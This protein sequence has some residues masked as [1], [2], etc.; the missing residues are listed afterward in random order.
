MILLA[1]CISALS[2]TQAE[3][4]K[5]FRMGGS[6]AIATGTIY[7][8]PEY[9]APEL[10]RVLVFTGVHNVDVNR[11]VIEEFGKIGVAAFNGV[12]FFPPI[13]EYTQEEIEAFCRERHINGIID[14][15]I[16]DRWISE[17]IIS[18]EIEL[19]LVNV[20]DN[21]NIAAVFGFVRS[22]HADPDKGMAK[23]FEAVVKELDPILKGER[24]PEN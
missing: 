3:A 20:G 9:V 14:T 23:F 2:A 11:S 13:K 17:E 6:S 16:N 18:M 24:E 10:S 8:D 12:A 21:S 7:V 4:Q 5:A 1:G 22:A 19:S 15:H